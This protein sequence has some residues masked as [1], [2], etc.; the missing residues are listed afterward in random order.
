M[1]LFKATSIPPEV[2]QL[3]LLAQGKAA[4]DAD[5]PRAIETAAA[6]IDRQCEKQHDV[7]SYLPLLKLF[8][9]SA[10]ARIG[11]KA[12]FFSLRNRLHV[13]E[14]ITGKINRLL[15]KKEITL[16][17]A[18]CYIDSV[19]EAKNTLVENLSGNDF[20]FL[21]GIPPNKESFDENVAFGS[22]FAE[23]LY[24]P[25]YYYERVQGDLLVQDINS[26]ATNLLKGK[27]LSREQLEGYINLVN[28]VTNLVR[29]ELNMKNAELKIEEVSF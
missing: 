20:Y 18:H 19:C 12:Y 25:Y 16:A 1:D 2:L 15:G 9:P 23:K 22:D 17:T 4:P 27:G 6:W 3:V 5:S 8:E 24:R 10:R 14:R 13:L 7:D 29:T 11:F 28:K 21:L 26:R